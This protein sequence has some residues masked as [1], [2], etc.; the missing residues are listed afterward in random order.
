MT[1][2]QRLY[3]S[4]VLMIVMPIVLTAIVLGGVFFLF[5]L[6]RWAVIS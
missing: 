4:N 2:R 5:S 3:F 1:I 6:K